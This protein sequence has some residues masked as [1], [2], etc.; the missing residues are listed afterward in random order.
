MLYIQENV[1]YWMNGLFIIQHSSIEMNI[2]NY[3]N[4]TGFII[5]E[6]LSVAGGWW[7]RV[8]TEFHY[9]VPSESGSIA[10]KNPDRL[11]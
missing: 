10:I 3:V 9:Q 6:L 4:H 7:L 11:Q 2:I 5:I 8:R 1:S